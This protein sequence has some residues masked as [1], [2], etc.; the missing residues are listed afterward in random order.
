MAGEVIVSSP[1][2]SQA[3]ETPK[4]TFWDHA[5]TGP[6]DGQDK[7]GQDAY[8]QFNVNLVT[9]WE[10]V[11]LA[12][13]AL[14]GVCR[15]RSSGRSRKVDVAGAPMEDVEVLNDLGATSA[16]VAIT[17]KVWT[18]GHLAQ[19]ERFM[20]AARDWFRA[21]EAA[22]VKREQPPGLDVIHPGLNL[23]GVTSLYLRQ[24]GVLEPGAERGTYESTILAVEY[25]HR[26]KP[27]K[28]KAVKSVDSSLDGLDKKSVAKE[29]RPKQKPSET[30]GK[31]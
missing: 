4:T 2:T 22:A 16:E 28:D 9:A 31:P 15:V 26:P 23:A 25:R 30:Q 27:K 6:G 10:R 13:L 20:D 18:P 14:P 8:V 29:L 7:W 1:P 11:T 24:V 21:A 19:W 17:V 3:S 5:P 12:G